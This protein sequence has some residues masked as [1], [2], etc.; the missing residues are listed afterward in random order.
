VLNAWQAANHLAPVHLLQRLKMEMA[1]M[2]VPLPRRRVVAHGEAH[3]TQRL[4]GQLVQAVWCAL[5]LEQELVTPVEDHHHA[6]PDVDVV[7]VLVELAQA[8][9]SGHC[10]SGVE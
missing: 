10:S 2:C 3:K 9:E 1:E 6:T 5:H 4:H 8:Q 7:E